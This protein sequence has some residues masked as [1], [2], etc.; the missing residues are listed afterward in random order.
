MN[1]FIVLICTFFIFQ[2]SSSVFKISIS[3]TSKKLDEIVIFTEFKNHND[4][5]VHIDLTDEYNDSKLPYPRN[6]TI[7]I[8][9][10]KME[11]I[12][13]QYD[14]YRI[15]SW[16]IGQNDHKIYALTKGESIGTK[17]KLINMLSGNSIKLPKKFYVQLHNFTFN[18]NQPS[19]CESN[20]ILVSD[21]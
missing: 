21:K 6:M 17:F 20:K 19:F 2:D 12:L 9:N 5:I 11:K 18:E 7:S 10:L 15:R 8:Y 14:S 4:S 3:G 16:R 13:N 1:L